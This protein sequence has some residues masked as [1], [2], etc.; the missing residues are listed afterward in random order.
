M[1][2]TFPDIDYKDMIMELNFDLQN[3]YV[4]EDSELYVI[5]QIESVFVEKCEKEVFPVID[6]FYFLPELK[7]EVKTMSVLDAKKVCFEALDLLSGDDVP[8][9]ESLIEAVSVLTSD[10]KQYTKGNNKRNEKLCKIVYT[11]NPEV[12]MMIYFDDE[13]ASDT[14]EVTNAAK[15]MEELKSCS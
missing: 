9:K 14:L 4:K 2:Q 10:L 3:G 7:L 8:N 13:G 1:P 5:R 11:L 6:Y 15:L 12:P